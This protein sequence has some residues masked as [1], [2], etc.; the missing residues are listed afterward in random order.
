MSTD[1]ANYGDNFLRVVHQIPLLQNEF[2]VGS[3][4]GRN[5]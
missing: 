4:L 1:T 3:S 2:L 5:L